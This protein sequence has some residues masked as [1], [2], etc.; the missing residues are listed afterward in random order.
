[1]ENLGPCCRELGL[2]CGDLGLFGG[3]LGLVCADSWLF[4]EDLGP[5]ELH[6]C[7]LTSNLYNEGVHTG[8]N[9]AL[10]AIAN[11]K[12]GMRHV[13]AFNLISL[14]PC[15]ECWHFQPPRRCNLPHPLRTHCHPLACVSRDT[16]ASELP[17][18]GTLE[19]R[20]IG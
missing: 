14:L 11:C 12:H 6:V 13:W 8:H 17:H 15:F 10:L 4:C 18:S 7:V 20:H 16:A 19:P 9:T 2:F 3:D 5:S 1:M